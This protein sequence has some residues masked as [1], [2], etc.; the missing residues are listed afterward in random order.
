M[1]WT[2]F[3]R[4]AHKQRDGLREERTGLDPDRAALIDRRIAGLDALLAE[5]N[6]DDV[7]DE[8]IHR[9]N[10]I[11]AERHNPLKGE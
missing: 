2:E 8:F 6:I 9:R 4:W 11:A 3:L 1:N 5:P 7:V 10:K